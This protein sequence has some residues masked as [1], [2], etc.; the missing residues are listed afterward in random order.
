MCFAI[1]KFNSIKCMSKLERNRDNEG[2]KEEKQERD[3]YIQTKN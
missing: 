2:W 1:K 3:I